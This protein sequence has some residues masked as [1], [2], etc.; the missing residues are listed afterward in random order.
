MGLRWRTE[1]EVVVGKGQ[2]ACGAKSCDE[3]RALASYEVR[4]LH[5]LQ[6]IKSVWEEWPCV[7]V[8]QQHPVHFDLWVLPCFAHVCVCVVTVL[9]ST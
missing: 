2:F 5:A 7:L 6:H 9:R 8:A 1:Q 4:C 3:R